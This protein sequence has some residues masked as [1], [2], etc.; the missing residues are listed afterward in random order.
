MTVYCLERN[1]FVR[2]RYCIGYGMIPTRSIAL[3]E[4][5]LLPAVHTAGPNDLILA[6]GFSCR[7][8]LRDLAGISGIH[9]G[10]Y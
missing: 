8:Q 4:R 2:G 6:D 5:S 9:L 7:T 3:A 1:G 10:N